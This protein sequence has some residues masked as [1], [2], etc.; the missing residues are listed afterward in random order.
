MKKSD[1]GKIVITEFR[2][3]TAGGKLIRKLWTPHNIAHQFDYWL[4]TFETPAITINKL[5]LK[6][7]R[8]KE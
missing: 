3:R 8:E 7:D 5:L 6:P 4:K 2:Q 1:G